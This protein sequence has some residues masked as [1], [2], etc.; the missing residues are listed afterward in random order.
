MPGGVDQVEVVGLA[1]SGL[2]M[3][4]G[5]LR[6]D[7]DAA[8]FFDV[9]RIQHLGLHVAQLQP[10]AALDQAVGQRGLAVVNVGNDGKVSD[11]LHQ[12]RASKRWMKKYR[13]KKWARL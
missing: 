10:A 13:P 8:F 6:L 5:C 2:V 1:V 4:R 11:V 9:H 3:Q 12:A 7:G